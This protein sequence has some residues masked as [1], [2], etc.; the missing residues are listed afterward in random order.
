MEKKRN[1]N[2]QKCLNQL[3]DW[4][5]LKP[6]SSFMTLILRSEIDSHSKVVKS[7]LLM[8]QNHTAAQGEEH[9]RGPNENVLVVGPGEVFLGFDFWYVNLKKKNEAESGGFS[10]A[11][12]AEILECVL[13]DIM[14]IGGFVVHCC[15]E[16]GEQAGIEIG[17]NE[18]SSVP[19]IF[20]DHLDVGVYLFTSSKAASAGSQIVDSLEAGPFGL[21][22]IPVETSPILSISLTLSFARK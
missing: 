7:K 8:E 1:A 18:A 9:R 3:S 22:C 20:S 10:A 11:G 17:I 15:V 16:S 13:V 4:M 14:R 12:A 5:I 19:I 21:L 6:L 2:F